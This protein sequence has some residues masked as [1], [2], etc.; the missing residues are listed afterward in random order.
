MCHY[1][2]SSL[3]SAS[4]PAAL[5][6][7]LRH[8]RRDPGPPLLLP[9]RR[10]AAAAVVVEKRLSR[11][12]LPLE[13]LLL[14][15]ELAETLGVLREG[16]LELDVDDAVRAVLVR[17]LLIA[18][19]GV[20]R[21]DDVLADCPDSDVTRE[22]DEDVRITPLGSRATANFHKME[23][24]KDSHRLK[25]FPFRTAR[26]ALAPGGTYSRTTSVR[27]FSV[28]AAT[29]DITDSVCSISRR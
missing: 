21:N 22:R 25:S 10:G 13:L 19:G 23:D 4:A 16:I 12:L 8:V 7:A 28:S 14:H 9:P 6:R 3:L 29:S 2:S 27:T 24:Q 1:V 5:H 20:P 26:L 15:L 11:S 18:E 17:V